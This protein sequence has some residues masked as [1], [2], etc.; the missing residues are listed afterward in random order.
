MPSGFLLRVVYRSHRF[1]PSR[2]VP[3]V[4]MLWLSS[5]ELRICLAWLVF[6]QWLLSS[7]ASPLRL[8]STPLFS[9]SSLP[10]IHIDTPDLFS[11]SGHFN[12]LCPGPGIYSIKDLVSFSGWVFPPGEWH[13][14]Y[15]WLCLYQPPARTLYLDCTVFST[16]WTSFSCL[17]ANLSV[18]LTLVG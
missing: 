1:T 2:N 12:S 4:V 5:F 11:H 8:R 18:V 15:H 16:H 6:S 9:L 3:R 14:S 17:Q 7:G 13:T 10:F